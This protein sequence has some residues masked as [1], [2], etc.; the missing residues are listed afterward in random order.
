LT[1]HIDIAIDDDGWKSSELDPLC[2]RTI[3]ATCAVL[4]H[5]L[6]GELSFAF[7]SD[8]AIQVL[9]REYRR[10]DKPTNVLSFPMKGPMLGDVVLARE[11]IT[12]E[13]K[14]QGKTFENHTAHLIIHGFLHLL[15]YDHRDDKEAAAMEALEI[16]ALA[17][18]GIDNPYEFNDP[19]AVK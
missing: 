18:M 13:A 8:E 9:N 2:Y 19:I 16:E 6:D 1:L 5:E 17:Q 15:G 10:K 7:V 12:A 3:I 11:T 4:G 14:A